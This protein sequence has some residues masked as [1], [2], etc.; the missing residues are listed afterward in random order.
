MFNEQFFQQVGILIVGAILGIFGTLGTGYGKE[1]FDE[2]AR[3]RKH[4]INVANE[5]HKLLHE[6]ST[7]NFKRSPRD[8]E[9]I[10]KVLTDLE[11]IDKEMGKNMNEFVND[12]MLMVEQH[13]MISRDP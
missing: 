4:K 6:A 8:I 11:G 7:G 2:R 9:H 12:W 5:V 1:Y 10:N 3:Q 13:N